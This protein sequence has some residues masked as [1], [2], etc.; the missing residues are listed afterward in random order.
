MS[1]TWMPSNMTHFDTWQAHNIHTY[2]TQVD[3]IFK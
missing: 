1:S 3:G 2:G